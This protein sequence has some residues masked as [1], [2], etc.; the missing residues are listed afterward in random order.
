M[1]AELDSYLRGGLRIVFIVD[2]N[3]IGNKKAIKPV[4]RDVVAWQEEHGYPLTFF[5]EASLDLAEDEEL[6]ELMGQANFHSVFIGIESPNEESL[7]ETKKL[8]NVRP[9]GGTLLE[10]VHRIQDARPGGLVRDDRRLRHD[11]A[12]VFEA[13]PQFPRDSRTSAMRWSA[14]CTPSPRRRCMRG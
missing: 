13:M 4:L 2:D 5:T 14:C 12:S 10:R 1:L 11:D 3:L 8:Q 9:R 6:M 7:R